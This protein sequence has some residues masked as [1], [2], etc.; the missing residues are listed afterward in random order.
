MPSKSERALIFEKIAYFRHKTMRKKQKRE[1][2]ALQEN[3][4]AS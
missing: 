4:E 1:N 3:D 2:F